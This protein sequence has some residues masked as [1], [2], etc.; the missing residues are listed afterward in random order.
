VRGWAGAAVEQVE[1][2][3]LDATTMSHDSPKEKEAAYV[4]QVRI[5][6]ICIA[7][8]SWSNGLQRKFSIQ[9]SHTQ[10]PPLVKRINRV[11]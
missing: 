1:K 2:H 4:S 6:Q 7:M 11:F 9:R 8:N 3:I 5:L 10:H